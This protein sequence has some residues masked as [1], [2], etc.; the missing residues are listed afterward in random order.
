MES[1]FIVTAVVGFVELLRRLQL[2]D[3]FAAITIVGSALIGVVAGLMH[4]PGVTDAWAGLVIG[5]GAPGLITIASRPGT[6]PV[7]TKKVL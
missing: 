6:A 4:A 7:V 2:R 5:L 1:I 3:Y